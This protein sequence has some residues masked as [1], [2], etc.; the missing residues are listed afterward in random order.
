MIYEFGVMSSKWSLESDD[1]TTAYIAMA[2]HIGKNIPIAVYKPQHYGFMP[3]E[4][5]D[6]NMDT[7]EPEKVKKCLD[8]IK[9][10]SQS[11][12]SEKE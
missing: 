4:I 5:L 9:E 12:G 10:L 7:F 11:T 2:M 3:K 6:N 8:T 1:M